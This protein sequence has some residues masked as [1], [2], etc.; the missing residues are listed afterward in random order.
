MP[1][2]TAY[3]RPASTLR[4]N[5][6]QILWHSDKIQQKARKNEIRKINDSFRVEYSRDECT[7]VMMVIIIITA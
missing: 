6:Y 2:A 1:V 7:G 5:R 4:S 3:S